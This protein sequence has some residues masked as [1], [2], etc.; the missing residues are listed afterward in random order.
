MNK[1]V[2]IAVAWSI[3]FVLFVCAG[4]LLR[5]DLGLVRY[6]RAHNQVGKL[7]PE[8]ALFALDGHAT[9][10]TAFRGHPV[11]LN[12]FATWCVPCKAEIPDIEREYRKFHRGGLEVLGL[13]QQEPKSL[14]AAFVGPFGLSFP[15]FIDRGDAAD[16]YR[17][18]AIPTSVFIDRN[19]F[20]RALHT[21][22]MTMDQME[23]DLKKIM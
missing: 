5:R 9:R 19:G 23:T 18:H 13:D 14:V 2:S 3:V 7:A 16:A 1:R 4:L 22:A 15:L 20:V 10:L 6:D 12:F 17:V 21:G 11:W 8:V